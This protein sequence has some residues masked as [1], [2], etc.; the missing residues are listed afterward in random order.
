MTTL[1]DR[2]LADIQVDDCYHR[3]VTAATPRS[4]ALWGERFTAAV[5]ER[6][7]LRSAKEIEQIEREKGLR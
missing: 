5:N 7:R 2:T 1:P 3:M 6:N 4:R